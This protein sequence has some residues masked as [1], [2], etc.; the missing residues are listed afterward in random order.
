MSRKHLHAHKNDDDEIYGAQS[1]CA[2]D[3]QNRD[4]CCE[5]VVASPH[6]GR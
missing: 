1:A 6:D 4:V 5:V 3:D 2:Q